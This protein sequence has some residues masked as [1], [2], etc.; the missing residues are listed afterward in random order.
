M[1]SISGFKF[2]MR[3]KWRSNTLAIYDGG[4]DENNA[5][6]AGT[7]STAK[8]CMPP[9]DSPRTTSFTLAYGL[10]NST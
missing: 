7:L 6:L 8:S 9:C 1:L 10:A 5:L 3:S 4:L 2:D